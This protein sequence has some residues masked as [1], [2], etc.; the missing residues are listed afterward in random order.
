MVFHSGDQCDRCG[1]KFEYQGAY[2]KHR[3]LYKCYH[4]EK[5]SSCKYCGKDYQNKYILANHTRRVHTSKDCKDCGKQI[6]SSNFGRHLLTHSQ[7][8][9]HKCNFCGKDFF[10]KSELARHILISICNK[11]ENPMF[12]TCET[13]GKEFTTKNNLKQHELL[14]VRAK[15]PKC[16]PELIELE[17]V[18]FMI[19]NE[20][21][22]SPE[23]KGKNGK[24]IDCDVCNFTT[25]KPYNLKRHKYTKHLTTPRKVAPGRGRK[26]KDSS[27]W[28]E[29]TRRAYAKREI[30]KFREGMMKK[31][32]LKNVEDIIE[33]EFKK[34]L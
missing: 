17:N 30:K 26:V 3:K 29:K 28:S 11:K 23:L 21:P 34:K 9:K 32:L 2:V 10:K 16:K 20:A 8:K 4:D 5:L 13:C 24:G 25:S 6:I 1:K 19:L 12:V 15:N 33:S 7:N 31:G 22:R 14:H 27:L 18:G